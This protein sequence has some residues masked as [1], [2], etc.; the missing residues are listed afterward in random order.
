MESGYIGNILIVDDDVDLAFII[1]DMLEGYGY[2]VSVAESCERAFAMLTD[3]SFQLILLD[4]NLPDGTGFEVCEE[5]REVSQI[6]VIFAS[7]RTGEDDKIRGLDM[8]ADDYLAKPYSLKELL[9]R[10]NALMRRTY[11]KREQ[12]IV[13]HIGAAISVNPTT[14]SVMRDGTEVKLALKE[15]DLLHFL[16]RNPNGGIEQE[17]YRGYLRPHDRIEQSGTEHSD[18]DPRRACRYSCHKAFVSR[19]WQNYR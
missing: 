9:S 10:V 6:P 14:R 18:G 13:Y 4:I 3:T 5:L 1:R 19:G 12:E 2:T 8:G 15:F 11:G 17:K 7:A 16:C